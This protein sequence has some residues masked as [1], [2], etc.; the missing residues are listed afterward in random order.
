MAVKKKKY[1]DATLDDMAGYVLMQE[2]DRG[3]FIVAAALL[4][5]LLKTLLGRVV[6]RKSN[7]AKAKTDFMRSAQSFHGAITS[8]H[9][10]DVIDQ[11]TYAD[12]MLI[13]EIRN[14]VAHTFSHFIV[15]DEI[16]SMIL[17]LSRFKRAKAFCAS[18]GFTEE[19]LEAE[20][21]KAKTTG[22]KVPSHI[23]C[24][25]SHIVLLMAID[26]SFDTEDVVDS[27]KEFFTELF[28]PVTGGE[29]Q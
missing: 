4:E 23:T 2:S 24:V 5:D 11:D 29:K 15:D 12:L 26:L 28:K 21:E 9:I 18:K 27:I 22:E 17:K 10:L 3:A 20:A 7:A 6:E 16:E 1:S 8:S 25:F 19:Y 13:K 14:K